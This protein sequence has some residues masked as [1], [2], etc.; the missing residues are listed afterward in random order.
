MGVNIKDPI[1]GAIEAGANISAAQTQAEAA[2]K[3][4]AEQKTMQMEQ[5]REQGREFDIGSKF[6]METQAARQKAYENALAAGGGTEQQF[7]SA[8]ETASPELAQLKSDILAG[9]SEALGQAGQQMQSSMA[10]EGVRG[11]QAATQLRR[12]VGEMGTQAQRDIN[13]LIGTEG[14]QRESEKRAYLAALARTLKT[15][16]GV[17]I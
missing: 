8:S 4:A 7:L 16:G 9:K 12:G 6:Q 14:M 17:A 15:G 13:Q 2:Q 11:G 3:V 1:S 10:Q 5:L